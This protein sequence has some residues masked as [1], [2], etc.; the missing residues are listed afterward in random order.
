VAAQ[1]FKPI[2]AKN[3]FSDDDVI[4]LFDADGNAII[5]KEGA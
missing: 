1:G 5:Q 4:F 2:V 3:E